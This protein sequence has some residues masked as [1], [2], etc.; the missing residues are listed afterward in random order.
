MLIPRETLIVVYIQGTS[1]VDHHHDSQLYAA[2]CGTMHLQRI[3]AF[4]FGTI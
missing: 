2:L 4:E 1:I 3:N